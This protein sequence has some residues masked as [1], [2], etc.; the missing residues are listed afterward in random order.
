MQLDNILLKLWLCSRYKY[1]LFRTS[2]FIGLGGGISGLHLLFWRQ[3][4]NEA[5]TDWVGWHGMTTS[6]VWFSKNCSEDCL[7]LLRIWLKSFIAF[8]SYSLSEIMFLQMERTDGSKFHENFQETINQTKQYL[9][10]KAE[11]LVW[12]HLFSLYLVHALH[13]CCF[14][15]HW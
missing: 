15:I 5:A 2:V 13:P 14:L 8:R 7:R 10:I 4:S 12:R 6:P 3:L 11:M 9:F 1:L